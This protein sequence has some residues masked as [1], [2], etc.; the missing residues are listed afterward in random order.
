MKGK[1]LVIEDDKHWQSKLGRYLEEAGFY[2]E[3]VSDLDLALQKVSSEL[4][5]FITID[6]SLDEGRSNAGNFEGWQVLEIVKKLSVESRTPT[7]VITGFEVEYKK[8]IPEKDLQSIFFMG[9][10]SFDR[11]KFVETVV[12]AVDFHD[13]RFKDD[14]RSK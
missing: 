9:K 4:F 7:M 14:H 11:E 13:L 6:M 5:H 8:L 3:I 2:V 12:R 1:I 10:G